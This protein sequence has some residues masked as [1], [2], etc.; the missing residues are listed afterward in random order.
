MKYYIFKTNFQA[1]VTSLIH[2]V[3]TIFSMLATKSYFFPY[4]LEIYKPLSITKRKKKPG[5]H[6]YRSYINSKDRIA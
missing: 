5:C 4:Y 3:K 2:N 6:C 1:T